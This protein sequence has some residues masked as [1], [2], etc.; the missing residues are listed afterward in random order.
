MRNFY[1][2]IT[3]VLLACQPSSPT[4]EK[5]DEKPKFDYYAQGKEI[6]SLTQSELQKNLK[7]ALQEGGPIHAIKY[8]N[9]NVTPLMDSLSKFLSYDIKRI[10]LK[11]RNPKNA[12]VGVQEKILL[13]NF[14]ESSLEGKFLRDTLIAFEG[15]LMYYRPIM[16]G[17]EA[18]LKCHGRVGKDINT[19]TMLALIDLYPEDKATN[20]R[21]GEFRGVWKVIFPMSLDN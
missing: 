1:L 14:L 11:N 13:N 17:M 18:C 2:I 9:I 16:I 4:D 15:A 8:C 6:A 12:A 5:K 10:S 19:E 7:A 3:L 20:Y 21:M